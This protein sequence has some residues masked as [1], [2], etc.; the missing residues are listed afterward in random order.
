MFIRNVSF[1]GLHSVVSQKIE[2]FSMYDDMVR[3]VYINL[4]GKSSTFQWNIGPYS[5]NM[6]LVHSH[7]PTETT[8]MPSRGVVHFS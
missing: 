1:A 7:M 6:L 8:E 3:P 5:G 4:Y 2:L